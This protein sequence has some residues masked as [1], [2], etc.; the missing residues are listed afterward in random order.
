[1]LDRKLDELK[2]TGNL[3]SPTGV[4]LSIL[5]MTQGD[6][7][8]IGDITAIIRTDPALTGRII[9]L[10]NGAG[11]SGFEPSPTP[12]GAAWRLGVRVGKPNS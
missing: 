4:G 8:S 2:L 12:G 10:A 11:K 3:P 6:D 7:Y 9:K 1:M 5:H